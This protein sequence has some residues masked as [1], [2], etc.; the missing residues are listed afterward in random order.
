[1]IT[2]REERQEDISVVCRINELAFG[3]TEEADLIDRLRGG[4]KLLVSLVAQ[5]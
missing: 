1:M 2:V 3:G 4:H 5:Q